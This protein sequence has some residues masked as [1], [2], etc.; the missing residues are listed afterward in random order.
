MTDPIHYTATVGHSHVF[1]EI[2]IQVQLNF[3][4]SNV[5]TGGLSGSLGN[6]ERR[7]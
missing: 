1:V 7:H 3:E 4:G 2:L 5:Y 6:D